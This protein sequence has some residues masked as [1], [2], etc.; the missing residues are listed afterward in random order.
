MIWNGG[1]RSHLLHQ[2]SIGVDQHVGEQLIATRVLT[3]V[4]RQC[5]RM[6]H[7]HRFTHPLHAACFR[8]F[9]VNPKR[10]KLLCLSEIGQR[11]I[12]SREVAAEGNNTGESLRVPQSDPPSHSSTSTETSKKNTSLVD[13]KMLRRQCH[14]FENNF[15]SDGRR[16]SRLPPAIKKT[17]IV[18]GDRTPRST[19]DV[20]LET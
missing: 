19:R 13:R 5:R 2:P 4:Y 12:T 16:C 7:R 9:A 6:E 3:N 11:L 14:R 17:F 10:R 8:V 20:V 15:F 18:T 1:L